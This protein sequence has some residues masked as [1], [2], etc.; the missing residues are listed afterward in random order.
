MIEQADYWRKDLYKLAKVIER[1]YRQ[2]KWSSISFHNLEKE[3]FLGFFSIR[4][5]IESKKVAKSICNLNYSITTYPYS[6][7]NLSLW[8]NPNP[9][10]NYDLLNGISSNKSIEEI[11]NQFIHSKIFIPF[12]PLNEE[13][14]G[15]YVCSDKYKSIELYY[16]QL[17]TIIELY[18][19][20]SSDEI[21]RIK[22]NIEGRI[23]SVSDF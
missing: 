7:N 6:T 11:C 14:V 9:L 23:L 8:K 21:K 3:I 18:L 10:N 1:R 12:I 13:L 22:L 20:V 17:I 4:K 2:K 15:I 19:S 16:I 5:L